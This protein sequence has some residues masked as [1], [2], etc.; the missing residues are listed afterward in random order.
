[1][2]T[3]NIKAVLIHKMLLYL[4][5]LLQFR[6]FKKKRFVKKLAIYKAEKSPSI[7]VNKLI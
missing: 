2:A 6:F 3:L 1:M 5:K 4:I 7:Q